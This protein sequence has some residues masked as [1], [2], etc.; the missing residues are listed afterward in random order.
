[1]SAAYFA[2]TLK[3][4]AGLEVVFGEGGQ[5]AGRGVKYRRRAGEQERA[6][7]RVRALLDRQSEPHGL[8]VLPEF[9]ML[10]LGVFIADAPALGFELVSH[11]CTQAILAVNTASMSAVAASISESTS[12]AS[13]YRVRS[14]SMKAIRSLRGTGSSRDNAA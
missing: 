5:C 7:A 4:R 2:I 3:A 14:P 12:R 13:W 6:Q 9:P 8:Q 1:M 11:R 10:P